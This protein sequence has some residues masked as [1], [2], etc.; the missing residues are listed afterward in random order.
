ML[1]AIILLASVCFPLHIAGAQESADNT[2]SSE[3]ASDSSQTTANTEENQSEPS[4]P[5]VSS[6]NQTTLPSFSYKDAK[7]STIG[8]T[9]ILSIGVF[10]FT[11]FYTG[12]V[13]DVTRYVSH[14]FDS[15][16]APW[17][18]SVSLTDSEMWTK[19]AIS[20]A[21]SVLFGLLGA[22]LK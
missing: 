12:I 9:L 21:A 17:S 6:T 15:A 7:E 14:D 20:S 11:Y 5:P 22:I 19:I 10:P 8:R 2:S 4:A 16:Y 13:L 3:Q 18:S 1:M